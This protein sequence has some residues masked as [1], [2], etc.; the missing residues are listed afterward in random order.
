MV[1]FYVFL[2]IVGAIGALAYLALFMSH[3][4]G[5][6]DERLGTLEP[7]PEKLNEWVEDQA[8][9][10]DGLVCE[11]RH[12]MSEPSSGKMILQVRYRDPTSRDI[13]RIE[14]ERVIKRKRRRK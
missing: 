7:L 8:Q 13:L 4:P 2:L 5:A 3:V 9:S 11:R 12:L 6:A 14:P 1:S 10:A